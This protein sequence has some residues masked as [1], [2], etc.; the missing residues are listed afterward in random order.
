MTSTVPRAAESPRS[1]RSNVPE[2]SSD[3]AKKNLKAKRQHGFIRIVSKFVEA[4]GTLH[5][6]I[7]EVR[8]LKPHGRKTASNPYVKC[9][10]LPDSGKKSK[11]KTKLLS[12]TLNPVWDEDLHWR[13]ESRVDERN[14]QISVWDKATK[15]LLGRTTIPMAD[16]LAGIDG[17]LE[18]FDIERGK[19][20]FRVVKIPAVDTFV[21]LYDHTPGCAKEMLLRAGDMLLRVNKD[22]SKEWTLVENCVT[23]CQ[24]FVPTSFIAASASLESHAWFFGKIARSKA[25]KFLNDPR[26]HHGSFLI[27]ESESSPGQYSLSLR[28][29]DTVRHYRVENYEGGLYKLQG[30]P[31][32]KFASLPELIAFHGQRKAGLATAL[33][34][35]CP[36]ESAPMASDLTFDT[37]DQWEVPRTSIKLGKLLGTGQYGEVY[38]GIFQDSTKV[39]VKTLKAASANPKD[40]LAEATIMKKLRH[41]NIVSLLAVCSVGSPILIIV[42]LLSKGSLLDFL[43]S[44]DAKE[45]RIPNLVDMGAQVAAGMAYLESMKFIHRDLAARNVLVGDNNVCKVSDFGLAK[46]VDSDKGV[47][48]PDEAQQFPVRWTAPEA[49][50]KNRYTIKSDVWSFGVLMM[51]LLTYGTK[52]YEGMK[53][54]EVVQKLAEGYRM[55]SPRGCPEGLYKIMMDCWKT[56]PDERPTFESLVFILEDFFTSGNHNYADP[57]LLSDE[58]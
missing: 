47:F 19:H 35:P 39:A 7:I 25:E 24:G 23:G 37:H 53:N 21:A 34:E 9:Y 45:L 14:L 29:G 48:K 15:E 42:E 28:D 56:N 57:S 13:L 20:D 30:S 26:C 49:M 2:F 18:L 51:E 58:A 31:T 12:Q 11:R 43:R 5:L 3:T 46:L 54:K 16:A 33:R 1:P 40:F 50:A 38:S 17:W 8:E 22:P 10:L 55:P 44:D 27:R 6:Q 32:Q 41:L 36:K 52:P 4:E